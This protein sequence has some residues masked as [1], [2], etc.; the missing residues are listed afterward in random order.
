LEKR[1]M[2]IPTD[3]TPVADPKPVDGSVLA[4]L[5]KTVATPERYDAFIAKMNAGGVGYGDLKKELAAVTT[6]F[7]APFQERY[8]KLIAQPD[9]VEEIL[10]DGAARVRALAAPILEAARRATGLTR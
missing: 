1:I 2:S 4:A 8:Q 5:M 10:R 7:L 3:S 9:E 6:E